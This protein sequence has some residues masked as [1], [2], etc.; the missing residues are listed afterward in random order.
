MEFCFYVQT[1]IPK[2]VPWN[3]SVGQIETWKFHIALGW[4]IISSCVIQMKVISHRTSY[5]FIIVVP[6][7]LEKTD[8]LF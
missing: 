2:I 4:I 5:T 8:C 3:A 6:A 1:M 7:E